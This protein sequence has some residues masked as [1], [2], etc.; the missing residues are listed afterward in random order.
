M[1]AGDRKGRPYVMDPVGAGLAPAREHTHD[2]G[3]MCVAAG[4]RKGRPYDGPVGAGLAP[5]RDRTH[6]D[7][8]MC[9]A[10]GD[11]KGRPYVA[12]RGG[13]CPGRG[14]G[15]C[16]RPAG[17]RKGRPYGSDGRDCRVT[18]MDG[19]RPQGSPLRGG[20]GR[21]GACPRP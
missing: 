18:R 3:R 12:G 9:V 21:G 5:A 8:R 14:G 4:D 1:A 10:A 19:G 11:R 7:G 6:D 15:A 16:P 17:D 13:T 20:S 2:D